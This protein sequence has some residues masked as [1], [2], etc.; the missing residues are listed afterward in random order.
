MSPKDPRAPCT[1]LFTPE[2]NMYVFYPHA[3]TCCLLCGQQQ[4]CTMLRPDWIHKG[5]KLLYV[6][7]INGDLCYG[8][9]K[10]GAV[11]T[12]DVL[13]SD[14]SGYFCRYHER[15]LHI[16]HNLTFYRD[17]FNFDPLPD[18]LFEVPSVCNRTCPHPY[19]P[20]TV[21]K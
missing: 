19:K 15:V 21:A 6:E 8:Y 20:P 10:E 14:I 12:Y 18:S 7:T 4:G 11:T 9:G 13:Y 5:S 17:S 2:E 16:D 3:M 1:L